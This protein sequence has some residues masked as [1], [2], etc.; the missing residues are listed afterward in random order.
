VPVALRCQLQ[1]GPSPTIG[2]AVVSE[3][4]R[5]FVG[6][7]WLS[8]HFVASW[9]VVQRRVGKRSQLRTSWGTLPERIHWPARPLPGFVSGVGGPAVCRSSACSKT[10]AFFETVRNGHGTPHRSSSSCLF[11]RLASDCNMTWRESV[12]TATALDARGVNALW[13]LQLGVGQ[14]R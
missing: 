9:R 4:H 1:R 14:V 3:V 10:A 7:G 8:R 12:P 6:N 5:W 11:I 13:G 2:T